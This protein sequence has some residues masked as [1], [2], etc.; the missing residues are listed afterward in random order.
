MAVNMSALLADLN[1]EMRFVTDIVTPLPATDWQR[2]TPAEGWAIRDQ[3]SHLAYFD[4]TATLDA[5]APQ[6]FR[7]ETEELTALGS[8][9]PDE[10]AYPE[11][12]V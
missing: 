11:E 2:P 8:G 3:I 6:R 9:S 10:S 7:Q 4:E 12:R 5:T 1:A